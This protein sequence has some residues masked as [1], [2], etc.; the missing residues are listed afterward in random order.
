MA[1][2]ST[3]QNFTFTFKVTDGR[4]RT[5]AFDGAPVAASS[6]ETVAT[7]SM[8]DNGDKTWAGLITSVSASP[9][10]STQRVTVSADADL[11]EG[12]ETIVGFMD[13][14]VTLDPRSAQRIVEL[15]PGAA[16]DKP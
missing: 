14:T 7:V 3:E 12:V 16:V 5:V 6:D 15:I 13:F 1:E 2:F 4:G 11:G 8:T 10:G 9:E